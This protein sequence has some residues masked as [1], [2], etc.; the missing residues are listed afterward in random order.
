MG[1]LTMMTLLSNAWANGF[2]SAGRV[3]E[4][5]D[6]V[7]EVQD[8]PGARL[9]PSP[10][11]G[12]VIFDHVS[13]HYNGSSDTTVLEDISFTAEPH[14]IVAILG[15]TGSGK[16]SL[17]NLV[18]RFYDPTAGRILIDGMDVRE[19]QQDSLRAQVAVVPQETVLFSGT[20]R[21]NIRYGNPQ[22]GEE[23]VLA[24]ARAARV[25]EFISHL[26]KGY[27]THI[28]ERG[29]NLS[30]GQKQ[31]LAIARALL[32]Q[33]RI[34][35]LDDS[36]SSVDV[37]TENHIQAALRQWEPQFTTFIVAQRISTVLKADK[38]IVLEEGRIAAQGTHASLMDSSPIY[39]EIY[40]S[41]LGDG[42]EEDK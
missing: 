38:I 11:Q 25:D 24:A 4:V 16:T 34:L 5:L 30:G 12:G 19:F 42:F 41:Q 27:D 22:A 17:V 14:Q 15:A 33:P 20:I 31:R 23:Q 35:I 2:A 18:P 28:E 36:T 26:P 7:P 40:A 37:E 13:F 21:D 6:A 9:L 39:Q 10:I 29:V 32:M 1:P 8:L 3:N